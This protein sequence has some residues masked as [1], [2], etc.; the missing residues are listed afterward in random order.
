MAGK[1]NFELEFIL[2]TSPKVLN[3]ALFTPSGL[4]DWF[5]D[6]VN[7]KEDIYSFDWDGYIEE[8]R[9]LSNKPGHHIRWQWIEDEEEG[10]D[11]HFG[12]KFQTDPLTNAVILT[13]SGSAD[14]GEENEAKALWEQHIN[15]LKRLIGA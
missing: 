7:V 10:Y 12:F 13:V 3:N 6:D 11:T 14:E 1:I 8:A 9:L 4:A 2:Q 15:D 5:C